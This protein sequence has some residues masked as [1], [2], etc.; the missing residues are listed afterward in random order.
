MEASRSSS[1]RRGP[2]F[3]ALPLNLG[4]YWHRT[5]PRGPD[6]AAS[7]SLLSCP[8]LIRLS[9]EQAQASITDMFTHPHLATTPPSVVLSS[10][11]SLSYSAFVLRPFQGPHLITLKCFAFCRDPMSYAI[12]SDLSYRKDLPGQWG[13]EGCSRRR[14]T[15][16]VFGGTHCTRSASIS[17]TQP[18]DNKSPCPKSCTHLSSQ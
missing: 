9:F 12:W 5:Y 10:C 1:P 7:F 8:L 15:C 16:T 6:L 4:L 13:L 14:M 18:S 17:A 11:P 2:V 3:S